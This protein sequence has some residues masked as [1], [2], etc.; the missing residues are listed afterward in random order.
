MFF[1]KN[2]IKLNK[3]CFIIYNLLKL[4]Y[5]RKCQKHENLQIRYLLNRQYFRSSKVI[6]LSFKNITPKN[7]NFQWLRVNNYF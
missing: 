2:K 7:I 3:N 1:D 4:K 6:P 5:Y